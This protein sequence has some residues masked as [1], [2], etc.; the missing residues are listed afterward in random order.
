MSYT[1][2]TL[3]ERFD[4]NHLKDSE[5]LREIGRRLGRSHSSISRE[6]KRN[7]PTV[8]ASAYQPETAHKKALRRQSKARHY[9]RQEHT[10]LLRYVE[11]RLRI[12]WPP[13]AIRR[14]FR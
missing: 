11:N 13:A 4:I 8:P 14:K 1:H 12:D 5:S 10:P 2:L 7:S 6:I 9:R 3:K